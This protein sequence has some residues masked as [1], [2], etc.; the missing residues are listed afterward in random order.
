MLR[1]VSK[2]DDR[3][4]WEQDYVLD[5][6]TREDPAAYR[7]HFG[8]DSKRRGASGRVLMSA[9]LALSVIFG[10][11][12][13]YFAAQAGALDRFLVAQ[14]RP[15]PAAQPA[16]APA[17]QQAPQQQAA[18]AP[19]ASPVPD[20]PVL[21]LLI[22][23]AILSLHQANVTGD[24]TVMRALAGPGL[25]SAATP[26]AIAQAFAPLRG[27]NVDL[28]VVASANP[29]LF[30]PPVINQ[31]GQLELA[32]FFPGRGQQLNF[33]LSFEPVEGRWRLFGIGVNPVAPAEAAS[34]IISTPPPAAGA[35]PADAD[36]VALVRGAVIALNQANLSD[37]YS[38]LRD[39]GAPGFR[40]ANTP[41]SLA[42]NFAALRSRNIDL[43]PTAV[44]DPRLFR[45]PAIDGQGYLRL[46]GYFPSSP[47]QVNFDLAFAFD[48]GAWRLFGIGLN[49][50]IPAPAAQAAPTAPAAPAG[51]PP[52]AAAPA[53]TP[54]AAPAAPAPSE[55][56]TNLPVP[57]LRPQVQGAAPTP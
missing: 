33:T 18:A 8:R 5:G 56:I 3:P 37:D 45:A 36:L 19:P 55:V 24:Y 42:E 34:E 15:E 21:V 47:E 9:L 29:R 16:Q 10:A 54:L 30:I 44:I 28:G 23:N 39:L 25:Q 2:S 35:I 12:A 51:A 52:E 14:P 38:V 1:L 20:V 7:S 4:K 6:Q 50:S 41:A 46:T 11:V 22:R 43:A 49:T 27:Q 26:A 17:A 53:A 57:R 32:G 31:A 13:L 40:E 48:S